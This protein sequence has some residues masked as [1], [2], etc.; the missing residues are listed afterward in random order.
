VAVEQSAGKFQINMIFYFGSI[1]EFG[2]N[3]NS[4]WQ[5]AMKT[6]AKLIRKTPI[7]LMLIV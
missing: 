6:F 7:N 3:G 1:F 5:T 2:K 4:N